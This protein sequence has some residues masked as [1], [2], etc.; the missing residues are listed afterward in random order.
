[1][2]GFVLALT[3]G[4]TMLF[5]FSNVFYILAFLPVRFPGQTAAKRMQGIREH[6][7]LI[8]GKYSDEQL[9][10]PQMF[11]IICVQGG[12]LFANSHWKIVDDWLAINLM[13]LGMAHFSATQKVCKPGEG[14]FE[15]LELWPISA[16]EKAHHFPAFGYDVSGSRCC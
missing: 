5:L 11:L 1:M 7:R 8:V 3:S 9:R 4:M 2:T 14:W 13:L 10:L 6:A 12:L 16:L 15:R